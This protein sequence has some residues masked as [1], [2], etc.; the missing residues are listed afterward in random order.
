MAR[1]VF[2]AGDT[3][4]IGGSNTVT[5]VFGS[6]GKDT[7][8]IAAG[9]KATLFGF[10][11]TDAISLGGNAGA[12]TAV[13]SGSSVVLTD[14]SG[15]SVTIPVSTTGQSITF[16]DATRT[17][18]YN[19]TTGNVELG[20]QAITTTAGTLTAGTGGSSTAGQ[21]FTLTTGTDTV[22]GTAGN[23]TVNATVATLNALDVIDGGAGTDTLSIVD[24]AAVANLGSATISG[25]E[26]LSITSGGA[27][28]SIAATAGSNTAAV[29]QV[30]TL[31]AKGTFSVGDKVDVTIGGVK[32][33]TA[34]LTSGSQ[35][36]MLD[37]VRAVLDEHL[38]DSVTANST[39]STGSSSSTTTTMTITSKVAGTALPT[40]TV[41]KNT[42]GSSTASMSFASATASQS[43]TD[44]ATS[45]V[46]NVIATA[47][48]AVKQVTQ[49][50]FAITSGTVTGMT[51]SVNGTDY[52][53]GVTGST[54]GTMA[55][56]AARLINSVLGAGVAV[57]DT[58]AGTVTVTA[59][60]A[61]TTLPVMNIAVG[62][63]LTGYSDTWTQ[64]VANT[65]A[66]A[67]ASS[68]AAV[69]APAGVTTYTASASGVANVTA[70]SATTALTVSGTAVKTSGGTDVTV[71]ASDS[72]HVSG[73]KGAVVISTGATSTTMIGAVASDSG[74]TAGDAAGVYVSGGTTVSVTV[75]STNAG[76]IKI[77]A[78]GY[79][80]AA[81]ND[82]GYPQSL[83]NATVAP[84]GNVT[85]G[86][87]KGTADTTTGK[88]DA[89]Y[90]SGAVTIYMNGGTTATVR[91]GGTTSITDIQTTTLKSSASADAVAGTSK[92]ST[93][94]LAGLS[95]DATITS[96]AITNVSVSDTLSGASASRTV[97]I[98]NSGTT[99]ANSGAI[100]YA[101]SN[102]GTSSYALILKDVTA[103][104]VNISSG[105]ASSYYSIGGV[106][107]NDGS[108][109]YVAIKADKATSLN[110]TNT[111]AV[112]IDQ[113]NSTLSKVTAITASGSGEVN[114]G[115]VSTL[116]SAQTGLSTINASA[117]SGAL[118][119]TL[120]ATDTYHG[121]TVTGGSGNDVVVLSGALGV[122]TTATGNQVTTTINLGAGNDALID[123]DGAGTT[124]VVNAGAVIDAGD[125]VDTVSST[126]L[127]SGNAAL[128]KNFEV[129]DLKGDNRSIDVSL[130]TNSNFSGI[131]LTGAVNTSA[132]VSKLS[133]TVL[134]ATITGTGALGS[135]TATLATSTGTSDVGNIT[136][137]AKDFT[138]SQTNSLTE[139]K[140]T[141]LE[142]VNISSG[143][144]AAFG[145]AA[146]VVATNVIGTLTDTSNSTASIVITGGSAFKL[147]EYNTASAT[148]SA[149]STGYKTGI[150]QN[151]AATTA[152]ADVASALKLI[153]G[154]AASGA[155]TIVAGAKASIDGTYFTVYDG[156][157]IKGGAKG[158]T[159]V[160]DAKLGV[161]D[162]GAGDDTIIITGLGAT[163]L[164]GDGADTIYAWNAKQTVNVG[165][166]EKVDTV[167]L[168]TGADFT[169][170]SIS[171][172][173]A[174]SPVTTLVGMTK[175]D[176]ID[177]SAQLNG[178]THDATTPANGLVTF[179]A[180]SVAAYTALEDAINA[181]ITST[182]NEVDWFVFGGNTYIVVDGKS[183]GS[184]N[185]N[186]AV[187]KFAGELDLSGA[188]LGFTL[189]TTTVTSAVL[190]LG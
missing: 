56:D 133:G 61:G 33:T 41:A 159:L 52:V 166:D 142:T 86:G 46:S 29:Q 4:T 175:G 109:S 149:G 158:D 119:V 128:F 92:L 164:G 55:T 183:F 94:N 102:V 38:G 16:G 39:Y 187:V 137:A 91:G 172:F 28:G 117:A 6:S 53:G 49:I 10:D 26:T 32:Y 136:F 11:S 170:T 14:A 131:A 42:Y 134:G 145:S 44:G 105:A 121:L 190:T 87:V 155:L 57:A 45:V 66:N 8:T 54:I 58:T 31:V 71:T 43:T 140:S 184:T 120:G 97:E 59:P 157:T 89:T 108:R 48:V 186:D 126:L 116:V 181:A 17:L 115:D 106:T 84:S 113:A 185:V 9:A 50:K 62:G 103:S 70:A 151:S 47:P 30:R 156:L 179:G 65:A 20:G 180:F 99:G 104:T 34:A 101:L 3:F 60:T 36:A 93:V 127:G 27:I 15:G 98:K 150:V 22:T 168:G 153:D 12:Y 169:S 139:F 123:G 51:L 77:G 81:V 174:T 160:N 165:S 80:K 152:T 132:S 2:N 112:N 5:E 135:V 72:V 182:A 141:G 147:G 138:T 146:T 100:N 143:G 110:F 1:L 189:S 95:G 177:L 18:V 21:T 96:D 178:L 67:A 107:I 76:A 111:L 79:A 162:G 144:T 35:S 63:T 85:V 83:G 90:Q 75:G 68:A 148:Y 188:A 23:D 154:S 176:K 64:L 69:V 125:G 163:A 7:I 82:T 122:Q 118:K 130:F 37:A 40:I 24:T 129:L 167:V 161:V 13:R 25:I 171:T 78:A 114:L 173:S 124:A 19:T 73:A 74:S 88:V